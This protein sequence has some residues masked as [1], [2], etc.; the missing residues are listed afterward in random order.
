MEK[1]TDEFG[2]VE[3]KQEDCDFCENK[4][5]HFDHSRRMSKAIKED[6]FDN[7][8][9]SHISEKYLN[10]NSDRHLNLNEKFS[11]GLFSRTERMMNNSLSKLK[12]VQEDVQEVSQ[13][14]SLFSDSVKF[15]TEDDFVDEDEVKI[16]MKTALIAETYFGKNR[17][18]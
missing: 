18:K 2:F 15:E 8:F 17:K 7:L 13:K 16:N 3:D 5:K 11:S 9:E 14:Y 1:K 12:A 6:D 10:I 4:V